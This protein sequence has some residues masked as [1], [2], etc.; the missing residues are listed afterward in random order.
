MASETDYAEHHSYDNDYA[1]T[2]E[3][4]EVCITCG[5]H[6]DAH[7]HPERY[8]WGDRQPSTHTYSGRMM[9]SKEAVDRIKAFYV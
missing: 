1:P 6:K 3:R 7:E 5:I 9:N 4:H 8:G 2:Q